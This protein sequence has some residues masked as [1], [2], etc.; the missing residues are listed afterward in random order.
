MHLSDS[1]AAATKTSQDFFCLSR[2]AR[3]RPR[4]RVTHWRFKI[5]KCNKMQPY[6][7][8]TRNEAQ[9]HGLPV[10]VVSFTVPLVI[11][12]ASHIAMIQLRA[13]VH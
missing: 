8:Q 2:R 6:S 4:G 5:V 9:I 13:I 11:F 3:F 10:N 7:P 1:M 12:G